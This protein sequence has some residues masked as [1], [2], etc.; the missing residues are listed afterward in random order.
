MIHLRKRHI[1]G[2]NF[3]RFFWQYLIAKNYKAVFWIWNFSAPKYWQ[4]SA[5]KMLMKLTQGGGRKNCS[6][7]CQ[8]HNSVSP[9]LSVV[10]T[11]RH[12]EKNFSPCSM[13]NVSDV[14]RSNF[15]YIQSVSRQSRSK[16]VARE[17]VAL[18]ASL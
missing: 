15:I 1:E 14:E 11:M 8:Q 16:A 18:G 9:S 6:E 4:K 13:S 17:A 2:A 3:M 7:D 5:H 12:F 10:L